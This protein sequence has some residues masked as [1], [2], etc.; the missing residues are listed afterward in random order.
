[1]KKFGVIGF[2]VKHSFSPGYFAQKFSNLELEDC[3]YQAYEIEDLKKLKA[4]VK[5]EILSGFNVTIP[6]K[7]SIIPM[8]N[9]LSNAAKDIGA[10]NTVSVTAE[11]WFGDNTDFIGFRKSLS[12]LIGNKRHT[13]LIFGTGGSSKAIKYALQQ[14]G[15]Q[16]STVSRG[17][18]AEYSYADLTEKDITGHSIL[19]NTTPLGSPAM[20]DE[21]VSI[22]YHAINAKHICY[23]LIYI[24]EESLFLKKAKEQGATV[25]NGLEM[26]QIQADEA[27]K[28]W[29]I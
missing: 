28:I 9:G 19:I 20:E 3:E 17:P 5:K 2:P 4:L 7:Q 13:A 18:M 23:D 21:C 27:W 12:K 16:Y 8:L 14:L 22:P 29:N 10:V 24:P 15:I 1:M 11:G 6:H 26:L 25:E